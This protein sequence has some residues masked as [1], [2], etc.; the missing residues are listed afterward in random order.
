MLVKQRRGANMEQIAPEDECLARFKTFMESLKTCSTHAEAFYKHKG[1]LEK[2]D[3]FMVQ[4]MTMLLES[5]ILSFRMLQGTF[6]LHLKVKKS[7]KEKTKDT[8]QLIQ[9]GKDDV[10]S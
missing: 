9:G 7:K 10:N 8:L 1:C 2:M 3:T 5:I 4:A 6:R